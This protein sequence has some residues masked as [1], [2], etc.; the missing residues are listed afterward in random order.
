MQLNNDLLLLD[1]PNFQDQ[2]EKILIT[3]HLINNYWNYSRTARSLNIQRSHLYNLIKKY[4]IQRPAPEGQENQ[5]NQ[6]FLQG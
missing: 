3:T 2:T 1:L 4:G 5:N 6:N